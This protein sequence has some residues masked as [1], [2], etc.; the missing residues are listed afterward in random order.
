M[1]RILSMDDESG[2]LDLLGLIL[3]RAGC[4]HLQAT[5]A[6]EAWAI[7][8]SEP[9]DLL[10]QDLMRPE[11]DGLTFLRLMRADESLK[12]I[13]VILITA[14]QLRDD[15]P[16]WQTSKADAYI[17]KP[18]GPNALLKTIETV[19]TRHGKLLP[20]ATHRLRAQI[21][22]YGPNSEDQT[23]EGWLLALQSIDWKKRWKAALALG[24][25]GNTLAVEPLLVALRDENRIVRMIA[26]HAL[27]ELGDRRAVE[28]LKQ[29]QSDSYSWVRLA[30]TDSVRKIWSPARRR[31]TWTRVFRWFRS[32][33]ST[34]QV[35]ETPS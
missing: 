1:T 10:T 23:T 28:P 21:P 16:L 31:S 19:L 18:F 22:G 27:G 17:N 24:R 15:D 14:R 5:S 32:L 33:G 2:M 3:E 34:P 13:P 26:A 4:E 29:A 25:S 12:D 30:A 6:Y 8:H 20:K 7:L 35:Q 9:I 11:I